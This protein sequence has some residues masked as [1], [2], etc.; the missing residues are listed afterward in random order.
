[1][2]PECFATNQYVC[3]VVLRC[4]CHGSDPLGRAAQ[5]VSLGGHVA[6]EAASDFPVPADRICVRNRFPRGNRAGVTICH[7]QAW[8]CRS[9]S[10]VGIHP[11]FRRRTTGAVRSRGPQRSKCGSR[12]RF[13]RMEFHCQSAE[14]RLGQ[15]VDGSTPSEPR[16]LQL[17]FCRGRQ[18]TCPRSGRPSRTTR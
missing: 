11:G 14:F 10:I 6:R 13:Q 2:S 5:P 16:A 12:R 15:R 1:M 9:C 4:A 17:R 7:S 3:F 8:K 18:D